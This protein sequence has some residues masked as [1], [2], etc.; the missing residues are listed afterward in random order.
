M[1]TPVKICSLLTIC[2]LVFINDGYAQ[3]TSSPYSIF[4]MGNIEENSL[5]SNKG[6]G[7]TGIALMSGTSVNLL[8]PASYDGFDSLTTVFEMG[9]LGKYTKFTNYDTSKRLFDA[10]FKYLTMGFKISSKLATSFGITPYSTV[11]YDI[12]VKSPVG[13]T[14]IIYD[15]VFSGEGGVNQIYL[16]GSYRILKNLALGINVVYLFGSVTHSESSVDFSYSLK[17]ATYLSNINLNYGLNYKFGIKNSDFRIGLIYDNGKKLTTSNVSTITDGY[18]TSTLHSTTTSFKIPRSIGIGFAFEKNYFKAGV[19]YEVKQWKNIDLNNSLVKSRNSNRVSIG[20]EFPSFGDNKG[21]YRM[22]LYRIGAEYKETNLIVH[23]V[24]INYR[25]VTFGAGLPFKG[26]L[27]VINLALELGQNGS[28]KDGLFRESF[29]T[30]HLDL[31]FKDNW[32]F[33]RKFQ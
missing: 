28:A 4:G 17:S 1:H 7:G 13:G 8:N 5:G 10:D 33:K 27:N 20:V 26:N 32:F 12:T 14:S 19:D 30:L 15:K 16:G 2:L 6:M 21:T 9:F 11:G 23:K 22:I 3:T 31:S 25:S 18:G 29:C 24:P